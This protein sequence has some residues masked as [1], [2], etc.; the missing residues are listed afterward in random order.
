MSEH[1]LLLT[2]AFAL[3]ALLYSSVGHAG[4]SGYLAVMALAEIGATPKGGCC[5]L[6]LT[7]LD[8]QGRD[9]VISWAQAAGMRVT[10]MVSR[11]SGH[12]WHTV[13]NGLAPVLESFGARTGLGKATTSIRSDPRIVLVP[14]FGQ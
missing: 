2:L 11:A 8:R 13:R 9:L 14:G 7:D 12:D 1:E 3:V 10:V 6:T 5:R 4:A